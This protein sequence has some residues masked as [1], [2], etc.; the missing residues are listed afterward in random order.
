MQIVPRARIL[1]AILFLFGATAIAQTVPQIYELR[2]QLGPTTGSEYGHSVAVIGDLN[3]DGCR[4]YVVGLPY[5]DATASDAGEARVYD[6]RTGVVAATLSF[7]TPNSRFGWAVSAAGDMTGD[8]VDDFCVTT[9]PTGGSGVVRLYSGATFAFLGSF[10]GSGDTGSCVAA[11]GDTNGDGRSEIVIGR[12]TYTLSGVSERGRFD[13]LSWNGAN[14]ISILNVF[15]TQ[16]LEHF[17]AAVCSLGDDFDGDGVS[18][19]VVAAPDSDTFGGVFV[20][21]GRFGVFSPVTGAQLFAYSQPLA[22]VR[23]GLSVS[24]GADFNGDGQMDFAVGSTNSVTVYSGVNGSSI[25]FV[26]SGLSGV[27]AFGRA[28]AMISDTNGDGFGDLGVGAPLDN[29]AGLDSG[30][31]YIYGGAAT[32]GAVALLAMTSLNAADDRFGTALS[33][34]DINGD[35]RDEFLVSAPFVD[36]TG[37]LGSA[38]VGAISIRSLVPA[39]AVS[40]LTFSEVSRVSNLGDIDGDGVSDY[41]VSYPFTIFISQYCGSLRVYSGATRTQ[42]R[43]HIGCRPSGQYGWAAVGIGD[44][45]GDGRSEYAIG[46]PGIEGLPDEEGSIEVR[47]GATGAVIAAHTR[48]GSGDDRMGYSLAAIGDVNSD[49]IP[50]YAIG[51]PGDD[52]LAVV[53]LL[54]VN[55]T[56]AGRVDVISGANGAILETFLGGASG[57]RL[58]TSIAGVDDMDGDG[59]R[60]LA[61]GVP[62]SA[63]GGTDA[64]RVEVRSPVTGNLIYSDDGSSGE[65]LGTDVDDAGDVNGDGTGD[66]IVGAPFRDFFF[67]PTDAGGATIYS[68]LSGTPLLSVA[69]SSANDHAGTS[70]A[71]LGDVNG[72]GKSDFAVGSPDADFSGDADRGAVRV[73]SSN[74][75]AILTYFGELTTDRFGV[76]IV[77][78]GDLD[79]NG[80]G[81]L[82]VGIDRLQGPAAGSAEG[83]VILAPGV[84]GLE[85]YGA[86]TPGCAGRMRLYGNLPPVVGNSGF[87]FTCTN[88]PI[89]GAGFLVVSP[90]TAR[91]DAGFEPL[92][93][94]F[95]LHVDTLTQPYYVLQNVVS[96]ITGHSVVAAPVPNVPALAGLG[97]VAQMVWYFGPCS[98]T[99]FGFTSTNGLAFSIQP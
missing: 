65:Q 98:G 12:P 56:D 77:G 69:G 95:L 15:G 71:G 32:S 88:A 36:S 82:L 22:N 46:D 90:A 93:L 49:G 8:G 43:S 54:L 50:D 97:A 41:G 6:G 44:I 94:G 34:G 26:A 78:P 66:Y 89:S 5:S 10:S 14:L 2:R 37:F 25:G 42:I 3:S 45:T 39:T 35:G 4:E 17:G 48:S 87:A 16:A 92:G 81:D 96:D 28:I 57:E 60:D 61:I 19:I 70:V 99:S 64:G 83:T 63:V 58:G 13:I 73:F 76:D 38:D 80:R 20:N 24:G 68:G 30:T 1:P 31:L 79:G 86:G 47:N 27:D 59:V 72:D 33:T 84:A 9:L 74:G 67:G 85:T 53:G 21:G 52:H 7:S 91:V 75:S 18:D 23:H 29:Q 62:F 11:V 40:D 55:R 51:S